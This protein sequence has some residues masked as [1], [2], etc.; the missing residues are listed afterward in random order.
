MDSVAI[1]PDPITDEICYVTE[2]IFFNDSCPLYGGNLCNAS[3]YRFIEDEE[4]N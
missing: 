4:D 3:C 2:T 1:K